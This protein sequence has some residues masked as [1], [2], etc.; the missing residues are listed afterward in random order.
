MGLVGCLI[1]SCEATETP[2]NIEL[3]FPDDDTP[4]Q[5]ADNATIS[6]SPNGFLESFAVSGPSVGFQVELEPD[7]IARVLSVYF[8]IGTELIAYGSTPPFTFAAASGTTLRILVAYPGTLTTV[9]IAFG[10]PDPDVLAASTEPGVVVLAS[11]GS[12]VVLD[13]YRWELV[14]ASPFPAA[15]ERPSPTNGLFIAEPGAYATRLW[16]S[17]GPHAQRYDVLTDQWATRGVVGDGG[18]DRSGAAWVFDPTTLQVWV[19]GGGDRSDIAVIDLTTEPAEIEIVDDLVLDGPRHGAQ[20]ILTSDQ[21]LIVAGGDDPN[22]PRIAIPTRDE[23]L[24]PSEAWTGLRCVNV[25]SKVYCGGGQ[26]FESPTADVLEIDVSTATTTVSEHVDGLQHPMADPRWFV[27][28]T[29]AYAQSS[30]SL[31]QFDPTGMANN[32][33]IET[34]AT[35][36]TGG[37]VVQLIQGPSLMLGGVDDNGTAVD[38]WQLFSRRL[39]PLDE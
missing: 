17:D 2:V 4:L 12:M 8:A 36:V 24:G 25:E 29:A 38:R 22:L 13:V 18:S 27:D 7:S 14:T 34:Q 31:V 3:V 9:P 35:R 11:D 33:D 23:V 16:W 1:A 20:A 39:V 28:D 6:L 26:R 15:V 5:T 37:V 30:S 21:D 32:S 19:V 10:S